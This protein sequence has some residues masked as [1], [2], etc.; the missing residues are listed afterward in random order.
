MYAR[1]GDVDTAR[2]LF[3]RMPQRNTASWNTIISGY[4]RAGL[5]GDAI[6]LFRELR[7][8]GVGPNGFVLAS[9]VSGCNRSVASICEGFQ[10]HGLVLKVGLLADVYVSSAILHLYGV[11]GFMP[12]LQRFF[13]EMPERN[14]VSWTS[15]MVGYLKNGDPEETVYVYWRMRWEGVDCNQN[16]LATVISS[17]GLLE[18]ELLGRQVLGHVVISGFET[19]LS[20]ANAL[21]S[22]FGSFGSVGDAC[23][24][25]DR[26]EDRDT[27]SWNSMISMY[28][29]NGFFKESLDCF[30]RM[31]SM[32][33]QPDS[34]TISSL[35]SACSCVDDLKW[36]KGIHGIAVKF[37]H[38]STASVC[39][40]L[41]TM[42]SMTSRFEDAQLVFHSM[43]KRDLISWNSMMACFVQSRQY[44]N[45]LK[46]LV[47]LLGTCQGA[48][49]VTFTSALAACSSPEALIKGKMVHALV[50]LLG[51]QEN[52]LVG[53]ALVTMYGKCH[54]MGEAECV[55]RAMPKTDVVTWNAMI[56]GNV[57]NE[58]QQEAIKDF[59]SMRET[60]MV[61]NYI[62]MVNVLSACSSPDDL[63]K[64]GMP[65][66]AHIVLS[67]FESDNYVK[68]SLLTM[69]AKCG[70]LD[71]SYFIFDGLAEKT[72]VSW[73]AMIAA[74]A[75][76][77]RG[78]EA[79]KLFVEMR[80][81]GLELDHFS[82]SGGLA[83]SAHL[84]ILEEGQQLHNMII[85]LGFESDLHVTNAA[86][87]MYGKCGKMDEVLR[88][89]PETS[90]RSRLSWNI[91]ISGFARHGRFEKAREAFQGMLEMGLKP[92]YVT[93]VS[94]LSACNHAGLVN[95]G[96]KYFTLMTSEFG[97]SP[98]IEH[99]VCMV[100]LL[101]RS[102]RLVDAERFIEE[103]PVS[104]NDLV[105]RS[106]LAASRNHGN[107]E[108]GK[109]AAQ[110]LLEMDPS[111]DSAYVLLSNVCA[112]N[113]RWDD[114][115]KVRSHME[116]NNVKKRPACSW[117]KVK[118]EVSLFGMGDRTHP[119][120]KQ[121][122]AKLE[123]LLQMIKEAGYVADTTFVLHDTD[124]EQKEHNLWNH[125]EKLALAFGLIS[126]PEGS[127]IRVFKNLRVC[128]DC[129]SVY[130]FVSR[131]VGREI[132][133][134]DPYRFHHFSGGT[135]SCSDYW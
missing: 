62:T 52:L 107:L 2:C 33:I 24:V 55:F 69:Y 72:V 71:S 7:R 45:A 59:N 16:S 68:N 94:L 28:S 23:C 9:L 110:C 22:M 135:C 47:E 48:N 80:R 105:W 67:G 43:T 125:S 78:E 25:F 93:F 122:Y 76:H 44:G 118:N 123:E 1:F 5:L 46:L 11:C 12:D 29:H 102:G 98:G 121:I 39:N 127:P 8:E 113:R 18:D 99:C 30:H 34:T 103:M 31:C 66:H 114:V 14:V 51:F 104:P 26:M 133:L 36:G 117:I 89:L 97:I 60:G 61:T 21:I 3:D 20:V 83:A 126:T 38:D 101:G 50:I 53:N 81:A 88:I 64:Y 13:D 106:L 6:E 108:L 86:M 27:I 73:N 124:D 109:R 84:A 85:K 91:L 100:D 131:A 129:H 32:Y 130:K 75:Y 56:G 15:L 116:L 77:G 63:L 92:D 4:V 41:I 42:Y 19:N 96:L 87:D 90:K 17:C 10:I 128:G 49:H 120:A 54:A 115:E 40:T 95:E 82:L 65:I 58:E 74:N 70:A 79:L 119:R 57:E 132:V 37:G 112:V 111:D 35:L 134:R